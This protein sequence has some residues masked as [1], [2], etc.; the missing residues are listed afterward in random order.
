MPALR[1]ASDGGAFMTGFTEE[2]A[3]G[4]TGFW[5]LKAF[6]KDG[7]ISFTASQ[8]TVEDLPVNVSQ[9]SP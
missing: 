4:G 9:Q 1:Y 6:A 2:L 3:G 7:T 8:V 5:S